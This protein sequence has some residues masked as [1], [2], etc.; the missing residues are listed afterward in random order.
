MPHDLP[1]LPAVFLALLDQSLLAL[2]SYLCSP[3]AFDGLARSIRF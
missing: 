3:T 1:S 2:L